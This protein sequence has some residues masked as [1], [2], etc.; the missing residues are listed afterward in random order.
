MIFSADE[1]TDIGYESGTPVS[2]D[3]TPKDSK[4]TGKITGCSS[5]WAWTITTTSSIL[6][7]GCASRWRGNKN[8]V[9]VKAPCRRSVVC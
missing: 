3:Y 1:T 4:F 6:K 8:G 2:P 7:N 5:T 9:A